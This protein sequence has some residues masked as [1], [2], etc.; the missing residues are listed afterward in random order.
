MSAMSAKLAFLLVRT[1]SLR[2]VDQRD[3]RGAITKLSDD[4]EIIQWT[5]EIRAEIGPQRLTFPPSHRVS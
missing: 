4:D 2:P 3:C 1:I 5:V